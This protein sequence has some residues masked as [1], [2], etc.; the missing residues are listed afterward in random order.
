MTGVS[1]ALNLLGG[2]VIWI[3]GD[4]KRA[5]QSTGIAVAASEVQLWTLPWGAKRHAREYRREFGGFAF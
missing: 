4:V 5:G 1:L 2:A 3:A